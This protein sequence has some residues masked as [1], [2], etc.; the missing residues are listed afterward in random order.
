[1]TSNNYQTMNQEKTEARVWACAKCGGFH[2]RAGGVLLT[3]S[4]AEFA[5]FAENVTECYCQATMLARLQ[6]QLV[7]LDESLTPGSEFV[8]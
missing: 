8:N 5:E 2:L 1:M 7:G 6:K 3:F 4:A